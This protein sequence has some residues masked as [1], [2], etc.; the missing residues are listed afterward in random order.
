M[1][2]QAKRLFGL[3]VTL[4]AFALVAWMAAI[5]QT[6]APNT[7]VQVL[8][9]I[10]LAIQWSRQWYDANAYVAVPGDELYVENGQGIAQKVVKLEFQSA[11]AQA[12]LIGQSSN[13]PVPADANTEGV[14]DAQ[15]ICKR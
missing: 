14:A 13:K 11:L 5:A 2:V 3:V 8:S 7:E 10:N 1:R 15:N 4:G 12:A 9:H 6:A